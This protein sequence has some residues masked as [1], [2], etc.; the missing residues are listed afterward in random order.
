M[1]VGNAA[2]G[3][4]QLDVYGEVLS[5]CPPG[6]QDGPGRGRRRG[7]RA[8][9]LLEFVE[10]AWQRPDDGIWE[11]RGGRRH[12]THSKIMAWVAIATAVVEELAEKAG[13][14]ARSP[15]ARAARAD[16]RRGVPARASTRAR[17]VHAVLRQR[18]ARRRAAGIPQSASCRRA[19]PRAGTVARSRSDWS[20]T[21]SCCATAPTPAADGLPRARGRSWRA[22]SGSRTTRV[23]RSLQEAEELFE[24]L[25]G[26]RNH[27]GLFSEEYDPVQR[28]IGNFPQAFSHLTLIAA[29]VAQSEAD[30]RDQRRS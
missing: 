10:T 13:A 6:A 5:G 18:R 24:R 8:V 28:Q 23:R 3:Q 15:P 21:A 17:R 25:L 7:P 30:G 4:F 27:L 12:F 16:P 26:L 11:V 9:T 2:S 1:R 22:A 14:W 29:A 19:I 20:A